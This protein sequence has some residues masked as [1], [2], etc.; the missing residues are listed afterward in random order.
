MLLGIE[1]CGNGMGYI[2]YS[3]IP[4]FVSRMNMLELN[5]YAI[6]Y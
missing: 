1:E 3:F 4:T 6:V 5:N 2:G